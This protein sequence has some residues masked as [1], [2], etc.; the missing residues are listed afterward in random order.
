[1][2]KPAT[3]EKKTKPENATAPQP[4]LAARISGANKTVYALISLAS[5]LIARL[6]V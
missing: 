5:C 1:M 4:K 6:W 3:A 2:P